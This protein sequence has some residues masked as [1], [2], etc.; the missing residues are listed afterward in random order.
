MAFDGACG[1]AGLTVLVSEQ[2]IR[3]HVRSL[4]RAIEDDHGHETP[5]L[6]IAVMKGAIVLLADLIRHLPMPLR[7]E[8]VRARSYSGAI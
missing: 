2:E 7:I 1:P 3:R 8:L 4:A 5:L 6:V